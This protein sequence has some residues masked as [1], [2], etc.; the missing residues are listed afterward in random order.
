MA[1]KVN[2]VSQNKHYKLTWE[3]AGHSIYLATKYLLKQSFCWLSITD[4]VFFS[5]V[6]AK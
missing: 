6:L 4:L 2:K 1:T 3:M 5:Q